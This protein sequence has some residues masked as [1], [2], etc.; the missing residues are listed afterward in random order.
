VSK[1]SISFLKIM[2]DETVKFNSRLWRADKKNFVTKKIYYSVYTEVPN[3]EDQ[4]KN[5]VS[6]SYFTFYVSLLMNMQEN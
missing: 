3:C 1:F 4:R 2:K 6:L 5:K